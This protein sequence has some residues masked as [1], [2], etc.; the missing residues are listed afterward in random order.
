ML[1]RTAVVCHTSVPQLTR[2]LLK[3]LG[4]DVTV[5]DDLKVNKGAIPRTGRFKDLIQ[6]YVVLEQDQFNTVVFMD[7]D[8]MILRP[9][10]FLFEQFE[11]ESTPVSVDY[12][13]ILE[14][15]INT[16][17]LME[18]TSLPYHTSMTTNSTTTKQRI[19]M[20]PDF[21]KDHFN[22]GV[23]L[24]KP[25]SQMFDD[26]REFLN[27]IVPQLDRA[28]RGELSRS[29]QRLFQEFLLFQ[30]TPE[31][32][33]HNFCPKANPTRCTLSRCACSIHMYPQVTSCTENKR[34]QLWHKA[35]IVHFAGGLL[36]Y[37]AL[38]DPSI[39]LEGLVETYRETVGETYGSKTKT[40]D[41]SCQVDMVQSVRSL[42][43]QALSRISL[44]ELSVKELKAYLNTTNHL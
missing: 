2:N 4:H 22:S 28:D 26:F 42:Y 21:G 20:G 16:T 27:K 6:K 34:L 13:R 15:N 39:P 38:T 11:A 31:Y 36:N 23:I 3:Q 43:L 41:S 9:I 1:L 33:L 19:F 7:A 17:T 35:A 10:S 25:Q 40:M 30:E 5:V 37:T 14:L 18:G 24:Y 29:T 12:S 32:E 8:T 44:P